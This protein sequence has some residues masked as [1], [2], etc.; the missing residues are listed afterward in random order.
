MSGP[1]VP[2][3]DTLA[4]HAGGNA[5]G[6]IAPSSTAMLE[7]RIAALEGGVAAIA[8]ASVQAAYHLGLATLTGAAGHIVAANNLPAGARK[9]L[10]ALSRFGIE[11]TLVDA[12]D[13][14]A[15][16]A[17]IR[18]ATRLLL[19]AS[20]GGPDLSV[21]DIP[22]LGAL[23]HQHD[24]PLMVDATS[25]SPWLQRPFEL[26]A[27]L[28]IHS[29]D[30]CLGGP[31]A[32]PGGLLVDGGTFDWQAAHDR[33]GRFAA[34]CEPSGSNGGRVYSEESTVAAFALC[35]RHEG[36][37]D[38]GAGMTHTSAAAILNGV[39]TL[40]LRVERHLSNTRRVLGFLASH[41]ALESL[42]YPELEAHPDHRLARRILAR[43]CGAVIGFAVNGEHGAAR[44]LAD[45]LQ[46]FHPPA[47]DA[48]SGLLRLRVGLEDPD[49]LIDD[50]KRGL[51]LARKGA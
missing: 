32:P 30:V 5:A 19:G 43:G 25:V 47:L 12:R 14:D 23:A 45:A 50:L 29:T 27:D 4:L 28:V 7:E 22:A 51:K 42:H 49:D 39:E 33:N 31:G 40:A 10:N 38:F 6:A 18:P 46:L 8:T 11:S 20:L 2:G 9:L 36:L 15:W 35:A 37:P 24:L 26:G 16:R 41:P 48:A 3:F 13:L 34:L 21:L 44:R 1:R 17:A